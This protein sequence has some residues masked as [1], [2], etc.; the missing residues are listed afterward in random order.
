MVFSKA[1]PSLEHA[2]VPLEDLI[3]GTN[4]SLWSVPAQQH[5]TYVLA[6]CLFG[7]M[8]AMAPSHGSFSEVHHHFT[9]LLPVPTFLTVGRIKPNGKSLCQN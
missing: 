8:V 3:E 4:M 7:A 6:Y 1:G 2:R 5:S 9:H